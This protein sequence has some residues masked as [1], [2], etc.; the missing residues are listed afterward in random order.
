MSE[1]DL[2]MQLVELAYKLE[3]VVR[4][5]PIDLDESSSS[6]G[7]CRIEGQYVL[8]LNSMATTKEKIQVLIKALQSFDLSDMYVK[9][10]IRDLLEGIDS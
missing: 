9:P 3:I 10:V 7:L 6:G 5:E 2:F 1:E 8:I 4:D